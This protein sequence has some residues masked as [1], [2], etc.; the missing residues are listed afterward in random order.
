M[1]Q[2]PRKR[3]TAPPTGKPPA[4]ARRSK[5]AQE[6]EISAEDEAQIKNAWQM[7]AVHDLEGFEDEKEGVMRTEEVRRAMKYA[8]SISHIT[9]VTRS[10]K[11]K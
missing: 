5:L 11:S 3:Q 6:N 10:A 2:P 4:K 9:L 7:F 1:C 8:L